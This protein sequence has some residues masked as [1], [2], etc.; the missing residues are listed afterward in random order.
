MSSPTLTEHLARFIAQADRASMPLAVAQYYVLD[1]LGSALAGT[2]TA[3]G[4]I[5][6]DYTASQPRI[7][8]GCA[9]AGLPGRYGAESAA[10]VNGG[11]S[12]IVEMDDLDRTSVTHPGTVVIPAALAVAQRERKSGAEFLRAVVI[13]Y[14]IMVRVGAAVGKTHYVYFHNTA[15][16]G[17][18][19]AAAAAAYLLGLNEEQTV[20]ALGNAGTMSA[21]LWEFNADGA[22]SKHLHAGRAA[23]S[24]VLAADLARRGF[25]GPR[26]ILEGERGFFAATSRDATPTAVIAGLDPEAPAWRIGGVSIKPHASC[27]HT[28]PA[29]D[30]ALAIRAQ[31]ADHVAAADVA[32]IEVET[33]QA[34]LDLCN[35]AAPRTPYQAKFSLHYC[36]ASALARGHAGLGDFRPERIA[37]PALAHLLAATRVQLNPAFEALYPQQWPSNVTVAFAGGRVISQTINTPK[38]DPENAL[39]Q[40]ELEIK[41]AQ[42]LD[43]TP[44]DPAPWMAFVR[45]LPTATALQLPAEKAIRESR[46]SPRI[47]TSSTK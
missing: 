11:L 1:W 4:R 9:V 25:T 13:G 32:R 34:A 5:L 27:R 3:Q 45:G 22:M 26:A 20:W 23:Q 16:C 10:L 46:E 33:Y 42:M 18:F 37:D 24:G 19:G 41:F 36:I 35:N 14:E 38:G 7:D 17:T 29:I 47:K 12:H 6:L 21:G 40:G 30:A 15:T 43:G 28:H 8:G 2:Q 39:S 44:F 31:M